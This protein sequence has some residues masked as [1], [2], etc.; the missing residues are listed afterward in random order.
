MSSS[1]IIIKDALIVKT[2]VTAKWTRIY[3]FIY[4]VFNI[5]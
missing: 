1:D 5:S 3:L 4:Y 2:M